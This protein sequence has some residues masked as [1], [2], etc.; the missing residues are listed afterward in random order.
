MEREPIDIQELVRR[1]N[2]SARDGS[3]RFSDKVYGSEP[4]IRTGR[5]LQRSTERRAAVLDRYRRMRSISRWQERDGRGRWLSEAEHFRLQAEFMADFEDDSPYTGRFASYYPTYDDMSDRQLRGYFTWRAAVRRGEYPDA[6]TSFAY[7]YLYELIA[8]V[9]C[10]DP[11]DGF[12]RM[13]AFWR[14]WRPVAPDMSRNVRA[15]MRDYVVY[16]GLDPA[17]VGDDEALLDDARVLELVDA[18]APF[19]PAVRGSFGVCGG[20][21]AGT[22]GSAAALPLPADEALEDRLVRAIDAVCSY[23]L[24]DSKLARD[25]PGDL[26]HVACAVYVRMLAY[27]RKNRSKG[28]LERAFGEV[29][30]TSYTMFASAVFFEPAPHPDAD[31]ELDPMRRFRCRD[32]LWSCS[33]SFGAGG[34]SGE[35]GS[36]M[37][38]CDR[39]LRQALGYPHPLQERK[40]PKYLQR[41]IERE[42]GTWLA[43]K[44]DH[45]PRRIDIDLSKLSGIRDAAAWAREALLTD[46]ERGEQPAPTAEPAAR[47]AP[48]TAAPGPVTEREAP[49]GAGPAGGR[50]AALG[51]ED[52]AWLRALVAGDAGGAAAALGRARLTEDMMADRVNEALLDA[53]GDTVVEFGDGGPRVVEDYLED[54]KGLIEP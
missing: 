29:S 18:S 14:A 31:V 6:P 2:E 33:R 27:Y 8:N 19:D 39:L 22:V 13:R 25:A 49:A 20:A 37:H 24:L 23:R 42:I 45:A 1:L 47:E 50:G 30:T 40:C 16:Y 9:G 43:W 5:D 15:W 34:R 26:R 32:G 3:S 17:L 52:A 7:V 53:V 12:R 46:E 35:L 11:A 21:G 38:A 44:R 41:I 54:V 48:E 4:I 36:I 51:G 28:L 10:E